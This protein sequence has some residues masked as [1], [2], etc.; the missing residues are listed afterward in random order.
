MVPHRK[1]IQKLKS[2]GIKENLLKWIQ[3]FLS[4]PRQSVVLGDI[5]SSWVDVTSGAPQGSILDIYK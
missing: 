4:E 2:Y 1:L 3:S 5:A